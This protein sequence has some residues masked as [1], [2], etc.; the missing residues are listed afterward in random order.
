MIDYSFVLF[1]ILINK[2]I[3]I[4]IL[5]ELN[6]NLIKFD[7][8]LYIDILCGYCVC[9]DMKM[10]GIFVLNYIFCFLFVNF[11]LI[12]YVLNKFSD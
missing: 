2:I 10:L 8:R 5:E 9:C 7:C 6:L 12:V 11:N 1:I 4:L 3:V